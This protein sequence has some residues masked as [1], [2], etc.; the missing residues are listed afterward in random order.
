MRF[1][2]L[3][4]GLGTRSSGPDGNVS[5]IVADSPLAA[6]GSFFLV[7][8]G[9]TKDGHDCIAD[10]IARG[11]SFIANSGRLGTLRRSVSV[12]GVMHEMR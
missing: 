8:R 2:E 5:A 7:V 1:S 11:T 3:M 10:A 4:R 6:Q 9:V 12:R